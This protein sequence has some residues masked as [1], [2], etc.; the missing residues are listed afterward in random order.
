[1][2]FRFCGAKAHVSLYRPA[3]LVSTRRNSIIGPQINFRHRG[4]PL[5]DEIAALRSW[6]PQ[7]IRV[8][9]VYLAWA[10]L[11][12]LLLLP[13]LR[14]NNLRIVNGIVG[15]TPTPGTISVQNK[16]F[17]SPFLFQ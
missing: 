11:G 1:M 17:T 10:D 15:P 14:I 7:K 8:P 13:V 12:L 2:C 5:L 4:E 3:E 9:G 6:T 16:R